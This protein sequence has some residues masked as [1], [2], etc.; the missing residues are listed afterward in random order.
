MPDPI[1][2][3]PGG[4]AQQ[5]NSNQMLIQILQQQQQLMT[6]LSQ[7]VTATQ[8]VIQNL[9]RD[10]T[11]LDS[12]SSNITEFVYDPEHCGCTF[13]AWY[14]R[15]ADLL[16]KNAEKLDDAAKVRL[17]MRKLNPPAHERFTSFILP[18]LPKELTF[19]ETVQK[20]KT[21]FGS[22]VS[23]FHR[24]YL[25]LQTTKEESDDFVSYSCKVNKACVDF[26]LREL[27]EEQFKCLIFVCGLNSSRDSDIRM[28]LITKL[29]ETTDI[30]LE[31]SSG[32]VQKFAKPETGQ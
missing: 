2:Q 1:V 30:S 15:Y 21:L 27:S 6:Q 23:V 29:N 17:L 9:S 14:A 10:E 5:P 18:K 28:R 20:L 32:R 19:S 31:K 26:K 16:D 25:C 4:A 22:T 12:L 8:H 11:V 7:Q 3:T 13:D 24:R